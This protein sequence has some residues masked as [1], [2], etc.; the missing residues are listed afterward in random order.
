M[1]LRLYWSKSYAK[2]W[3]HL[4]SILLSYF[5]PFTIRFKI[6]SEKVKRDEQHIGIIGYMGPVITKQFYTQPKIV[7]SKGFTKVDLYVSLWDPDFIKFQQ[8]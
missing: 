6:T 4:V 8:E 3:D 5:W 7:S 2:G 1:Q